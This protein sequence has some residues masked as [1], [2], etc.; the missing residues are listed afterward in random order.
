M[1][2]VLILSFIAAFLAAGALTH[3]LSGIKGKAYPMPFGDWDSPQASV[4]WGLILG[5]I[6]VILWHLAPMRFHARAAS[7]GV[8]LGLLVA[9]LWMANMPVKP[10]HRRE[11]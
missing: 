1:T 8:V 5:I 10:T 3:Y 7:L 2:S 11:K 4:V 6:A 9:G